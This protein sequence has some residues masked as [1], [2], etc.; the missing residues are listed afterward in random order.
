MNSQRTAVTLLTDCLSRG[1]H[2]TE[3]V[4]RINELADRRNHAVEKYCTLMAALNELRDKQSMTKGRK[5]E[6]LH[7]LIKP[8]QQATDTQERI[9]KTVKQEF[10]EWY[11]PFRRVEND[12]R[13]LLCSLRSVLP[14]TEV[15][16]IEHRIRIP[17]GISMTVTCG[18]L[19]ILNRRL[20]EILVSLQDSAESDLE[21]ASREAR[22]QDFKTRKKVT[23]AAIMAT[24]KVYKSD[25]RKW[26]NDTLPDKSVISQ[27]I[28][29]VLSGETAVKR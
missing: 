27:R 21:P 10:D 1:A 23:L 15:E 17:T 11:R 16:A 22:L 4:A 13:S 7:G 25:L 5:G 3:S 19:E 14:Y 24:A 26:R 18:E 2:P 9:V 28:E 8:T 6:E 20:N 12:V 29:A